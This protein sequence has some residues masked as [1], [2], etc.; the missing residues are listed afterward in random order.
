MLRQI[1]YLSKP[2]SDS[3]HS[4]T[5]LKL[6]HVMKATG[7]AGAENHLLTLLPRLDRRKYE[8]SLIV[9]SEPDKPLREWLDNMA[10]AG[11]K[12]QEITIRGDI[13]PFLLGKLCRL[14]YKGRYDVVH[15]HLIHAD[16][17]GSLA[18]K[19][20]KVPILL[21]T[22]HNDNRFRF[23][24]FYA[25]LSRQSSKA[26]DRIVT[27]SNYLKD[28]TVRVEGIAK[29]KIVTIYHGLDLDDSYLGDKEHGALRREFGIDQGDVSVAAIVARLTEQKG[30][31]YLLQAFAD[32]IKIIPQAK[33]LVIGSGNLMEKLQTLACELGI[34]SNVIFTGFR[35]DACALMSQVD[36][37]ILPSLWEGFGIVLLEA[38]AAMKP[39]VATRVSA[40]PEIVV[41]GVTG[42]L[43]PPRDPEALAEAIIALLQDQERAEAM[44]RAGQE[45]V[46]RHFSVERMVQQTEALYEELVRGKIGLEWVEG[47]GWQPA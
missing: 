30:H 45:R 13:D 47:E 14:F 40:I 34:R 17:Y 36:V 12:V 10:Q 37:V 32:V 46:E 3:S 8:V 16:L 7:V 2:C 18:A 27:V 15:T 41:D 1:S 31:V 29:D 25:W 21:S 44:G 9:F 5:P 4:P 20:T 23:N 28:F 42:L 39:I 22:R 35:A 24:A 38:M 6:C 43:V 33:L 19:L 26:A 11:V